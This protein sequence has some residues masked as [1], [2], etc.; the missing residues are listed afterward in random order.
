[1]DRVPAL[2][3]PGGVQVYVTDVVASLIV[4]AAVLRL[5]R[6]RRF[7]RYQRWL[8]LLSVL[9]VVSLIRGVPAFGIQQTVNDFRHYLFFVGLPSTSRRSLPRLAL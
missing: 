9:L 8:S 1:M 7:Y 4:G 3:L 2:V 5:L 6:Q